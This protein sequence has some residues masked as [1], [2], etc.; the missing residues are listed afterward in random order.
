[1][2]RN[3]GFCICALYASLTGTKTRCE[4]YLFFTRACFFQQWYWLAKTL[5]EQTAVRY[6]EQNGIDLVVMN[7]GF[8]IGPL[9]QPTL[10]T[11][12]HF[13]VDLIKGTAY[14]PRDS[15]ACSIFDITKYLLFSYLK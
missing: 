4:Q 12:S 13:I 7:P 11:S 2:Q 14:K 3:K 9:L 15:W 8:V 6:A 1:M 10:N 5:A